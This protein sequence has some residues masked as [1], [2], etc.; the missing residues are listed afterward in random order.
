MFI[1]AKT[2]DK[3][4]FLFCFAITLLVLCKLVYTLLCDKISDFAD[5][6][7]QTCNYEH[8][9]ADAYADA[10]RNKEIERKSD[11]ESNECNKQKDDHNV[12]I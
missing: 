9:D 2:S 10:T 11:R 1:Y 12:R 7:D 6:E 4:S 8:C 3:R 5:Q